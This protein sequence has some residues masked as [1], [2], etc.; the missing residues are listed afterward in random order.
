MPAKT[1]KLE[2]IGDVP[3]PWRVV[4]YTVDRS[5]LSPNYTVTL[6]WED[7]TAAS[8]TAGTIAEAVHLAVMR[9]DQDGAN[10]EAV[11]NERNRMDTALAQAA[12]HP[13]AEA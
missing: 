8:G 7:M 2:Q 13:V 4:R 6:Y 3:L 9:R 10:A 12:L 11:R 5:V 1:F